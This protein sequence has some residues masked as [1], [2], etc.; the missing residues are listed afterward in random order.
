MSLLEGSLVPGGLSAGVSGVSALGWLCKRAS[1]G[2]LKNVYFGADLE[3]RAQFDVH[4]THEMFFF[5]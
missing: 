1:L 2:L 3:G 4:G 5:K